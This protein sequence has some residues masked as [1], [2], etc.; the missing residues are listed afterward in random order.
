MK[1]ILILAA[2]TTFLVFAL[3]C[4]GEAEPTVAVTRV[5]EVSR[6]E[7]A[8]TTAPAAAPTAAPRRQEAPT[9]APAATTAMAES[10][11]RSRP[12][13]TT[14]PAAPAATA[15]PQAA[16]DQA[17]T[18]GESGPQ[19]QQSSAPPPSARDREAGGQGQ[20]ASTTFRDYGRLPFIE[21]DVDSVSTFS[22]DTDRTSYQLAL[23][24][25]RSDYEVDP[26]SVRAEEWINAFDYQYDPPEDG[27]S[28]TMAT[29]VFRHPLDDRMHMARI[30]FQAPELL[31]ATPLNV[32]LVLDAS[33]SMREGNRVETAREAANSILNSLNP[34][35]R[36]AVVHFSTD[37]LH[38]LIVDHRR[39]DDSDI[40]WSVDQLEPGGSTNVQAGLDLGVSL[41]DEARRERPDAY[42]YIIL[43]SDGVANVDATNPFAIL[44]SSPDYDSRNPLRI[45]TIGV[46]I[47]NYNDVLLE[48]IAQYGNGW[49]RYLDDAEQARRTFSRDNWLALSTP[50]ADQ[51]RAQVTWDPNVVRAWRIVGYENR[52]TSDASFTEERKEFAELYSGAATTVF[53]E[54]ELWRDAQFAQSA[55]LGTVEIRWTDPVTGRPWRQHASVSGQPDTDFQ[56]VSDPMLQFGAIVALSSDLYSGIP[57]FVQDDFSYLHNDLSSLL[58]RLQALNRDLGRLQAYDDFHFLLEH[59]TA[60]AQEMAPPGSSDRGSGYSR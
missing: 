56:F 1:A 24:W 41:A 31:D 12:A 58:D 22:L 42:N 39:P 18:A 36:V 14:A 46:G 15:A 8:A 29:D 34:R 55:N 51:T 13:A 60:D 3:G 16:S 28:F 45:I 57:N 2:L 30:G 53:Y 54:L 9:S 19:G 37:V 33:G 11:S 21:T 6:S 7:S 25:A 17:S 32:T 52:V 4:G 48:Q 49:Y 27:G 50:F 35:D 26:A 44:E 20:P 10:E 5:S 23:N 59:I 47:E 43:M 38:G 40:Q